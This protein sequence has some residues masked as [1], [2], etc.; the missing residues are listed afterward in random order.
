MLLVV[1]GPD[2][3]E[4]QLQLDYVTICK[5]LAAVAE[6]RAIQPLLN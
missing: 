5:G 1:G 4:Q 6:G 2:D 3:V